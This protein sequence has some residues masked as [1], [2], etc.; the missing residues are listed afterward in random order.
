MIELAIARGIDPARAIRSSWILTMK[1]AGSRQ[2]SDD[3]LTARKA[4]D[5]IRNMCKEEYEVYDI[6]L[7]EDGIFWCPKDECPKLAK[8]R[9]V[10]LGHL[11]PD[12]ASQKVAYLVSDVARGT[13]C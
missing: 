12:R 8:A 2:P 6:S 4:V 1:K 13:W 7:L 9:V 5:E 3:S 11:D 10:L